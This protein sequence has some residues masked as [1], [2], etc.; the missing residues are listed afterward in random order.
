MTQRQTQVAGRTVVEDGPVDA[1]PRQTVVLLHGWPDTLRLWD[2]TVAALSGTHR[3]VR[4]TLPGYDAADAP[5]ARTL[6]EVTELLHQVVRHAGGGQPVTLVLHDWGC[7]FGYHFINQHPE[8][9]ARIVGI[10]I[11]DAGSAELRQSLNFKAKLGV[12]G[13][14]LWLAAAWRVG[15]A[16]GD[17]M[18]RKLAT[19]MRVP[20]PSAEIRAAMGYPYWITWTG[21]HGSYK[22]TRTLKPR[23]PMFFAYGKRKP[24]MFHSPSWADALAAQPHCKVEGYR[25]GHWVMLDA[26]DAFHADLKAWLAQTA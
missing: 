23:V 16:F 20:T 9:V 24:F 14:Q 17:R 1:S 10:D 4:F 5:G 8:L 26:R 22:A 13:Y 11:G 19:A 6:V 2:A 15:G 12:V 3:C 7:F 25:A 18:A 21:S